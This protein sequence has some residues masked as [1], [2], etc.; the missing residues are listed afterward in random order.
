MTD[1]ARDASPAASSG[2]I[3]RMVSAARYLADF[4]ARVVHGIRDAAPAVFAIAIGCN[5]AEDEI[6]KQPPPAPAPHVQAPPAAV[7]GPAVPARLADGPKQLGFFTITFYYMIGEDEL[8]PKPVVANDNEAADR[9]LAAV[10]PDAVTLYTTDSKTGE[11]TS[12]ADVSPEFAQ[13]LALQGSGKLKDGRVLNIWG[14]CRCEHTPCFKVIPNQWGTAGSGHAL[15]PFRTV[16]V[17]PKVVKLGTLLYVPLLEGRTMPGRPPWGGYVHD[18]CVVADDTGGFGGQK[19]DLFVGR[20]AYFVGLGASGSQ[21]HH[22]WAKHVPVYDG[23]KLC[24]RRGA[25][26]AKKP[27]AI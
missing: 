21:T 3:G 14:R 22:A 25:R 15:Q 19:L 4:I 16:A 10:A 27:S 12:I 6:A 18:G 23:S 13:M 7:F 26:V 5:T 1:A 11:C 24:E 9:E 20:K 2:F 17:D 8:G